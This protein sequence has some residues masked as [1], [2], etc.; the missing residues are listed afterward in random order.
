MYENI[1]YGKFILFE[2]QDF[3][4]FSCYENLTMR[5]SLVMIEMLFEQKFWW[6][7]IQLPTTQF[8]IQDYIN[9]SSA[10]TR[11]SASNKLVI[12][13]H[14]NNISRHS[15][16]HWLPTL[17]NA[18]PILNLDLPFHLLKSKLNI[19]SGIISLRILMMI[20][21][22]H[23]IICVL[24]LDVTCHTLPQR[25]WKHYRMSK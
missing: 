22:V 1:Y 13:H 6:D 2:K 21:T 25:T 18:M 3:T 23:C 20:I 4:K 8:N 11:S 19:F 14:L 5:W 15:Y 17:W 16:F 12:P 10:N 7:K 9:F 24:V